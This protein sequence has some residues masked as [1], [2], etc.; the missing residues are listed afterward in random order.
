MYI[1][2]SVM[3]PVRSG[4]GCVISVEKTP[5][6]Q[7]MWYHNLEVQKSSVHGKRKAT[8]PTTKSTFK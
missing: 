6:E 8:S 3:Y 2:P 5:K 7:R 1:C 4:V